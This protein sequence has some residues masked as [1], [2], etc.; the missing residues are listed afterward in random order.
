[1]VNWNKV[2][3]RDHAEALRQREEHAARERMTDEQVKGAVGKARMEDDK[4][5]ALLRQALRGDQGARFAAYFLM[6]RQAR[7]EHEK[8]ED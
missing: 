7:A 4:K 8:R 2:G 1:M 5:R 6:T 3:R